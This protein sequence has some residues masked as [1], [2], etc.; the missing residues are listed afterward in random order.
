LLFQ[1]K[2]HTPKKKKKR[3]KVGRSSGSA[4]GASGSEGGIDGGS[5]PA[6]NEELPKANLKQQPVESAVPEASPEKKEGELEDISQTDTDHDAPSIHSELG[7]PIHFEVSI[8]IIVL[9]RLDICRLL[10]FWDYLT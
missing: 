6:S 2:K 7:S 3:D 9:L 8:V 1:K 10:L 4:S 5:G